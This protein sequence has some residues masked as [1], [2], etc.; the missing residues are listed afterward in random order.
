MAPRAPAGATSLTTHRP[1]SSSD[2]LN[3][4]QKKQSG[5]RQL[6]IQANFTNL[7]SID[8]VPFATRISRAIPQPKTD[9][10]ISIY[11]IHV[12]AIVEGRKDHEYRKYSLPATR[13][14]IYETAPISAIRYRAVISKGKR[15]G[16]LQ[17]CH[18]R[19]ERN[20]LFNEGHG[21]SAKLYAHEILELHQ[22]KQP[23]TLASM[24]SRGWIKGAPQKYCWMAADMVAELEDGM[25]KL[26]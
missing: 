2:S 24:I 23:L 13:M 16:E 18:L 1:E 4:V 21:E 10:A 5:L 20:R 25:K 3:R 22:L 17:E 12:K 19:I 9:F 15:S 11:P 7:P 14:W 26:K 6:R 8:S